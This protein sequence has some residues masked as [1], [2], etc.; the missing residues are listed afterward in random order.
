MIHEYDM[1]SGI[2]IKNNEINVLQRS[3]VFNDILE[4]RSTSMHFVICGK[5]HIIWDTTLR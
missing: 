2:S 4:G 1:F 5:T 3:H